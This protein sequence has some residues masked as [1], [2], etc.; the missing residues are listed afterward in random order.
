MAFRRVG[1]AVG[2]VAL[3]A[4]GPASPEIY[5]WTDSSGNLHF[6]Q[7][8]SQV[9]ARERGRAEAVAKQPRIRDPIQTYRPV[10]RTRSSSP[11]SIASTRG[12]KSGGTHRIAVSRAGSS[13]RV[14]VEL[15]GH[16]TAPFIIDTGASMIALP[17]K[18]A[19]ELGLDLA[20]ARTAHFSTANGVIESP[21]VT[22]DTVKLGTASATNVRA[23]VLDGMSTGLLGLSF[24]NHFTYNIDTQRGVV[25][26][27]EN[28]LEET[29]AIRGGR[30][31]T[32]WRA[33][34]GGIQRRMDALELLRER[35][36]SSHSRRHDDLDD[37]QDE[38][39]RQLALLED[40]ADDARV[41]FSWRD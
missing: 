15:N 21:L 24:F 32:Q 2:L 23:S 10:L 18:V 8:L 35:V 3:L 40:E 25:T 30:S 4:A 5:T 14:M 31:E 17:R 6:T 9:P 20:G 16:V 22:L 28:D 1:A 34:Y 13:M 39:V 38:L 37:Q 19:E 29:G 7:D 11:A 33:E 41:P 36:P 12:R 26:L 27:V